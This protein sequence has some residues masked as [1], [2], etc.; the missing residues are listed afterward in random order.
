MNDKVIVTS[1][2]GG[3][4]GITLPHIRFNKTWPRKGTKLTIEKDILR[5]AIYEPGVEYLFRQGILYIDDLSFK[6]ELGLEPEGAEAPTHVAVDEKYMTRVLKVMP[7]GEM[8]KA[9]SEMNEIQRQ[10]FVDFASSQNDIS[11]ERI[12]VVDQGTGANILKIIE[13]KRLKEE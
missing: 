13:L 6:I 4:I 9:I 7:I 5:E 8:K 11:L 12:K 10:E 2:V 3:N 1:M